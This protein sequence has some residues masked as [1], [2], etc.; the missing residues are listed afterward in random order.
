MNDGLRRG[1]F[2]ASL[3]SALAAC[4]P[5][6]GPA[7]GAVFPPS[8]P[9]AVVSLYHLVYTN[10]AGSGGIDA[11]NASLGSASLGTLAYRT[12][13]ANRGID[14]SS[15]AT[16][17]LR[18]SFA[19]TPATAFL[20]LPV[21]MTTGASYTL[22]MVGES[23]AASSALA[24]DLVIA[25]RDVTAPAVSRIRARFIHAWSNTGAVDIWVGPPGSETRQ[26]IGLNFKGVSQYLPIDAPLG[27]SVQR[28]LV[29][30]ANVA[31]STATLAAV[32]F[33]PAN[34][35]AGTVYG[36]LLARD[37]AG[38]RQLLNTQETGP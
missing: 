17:T 21:P 16:Q 24:P 14:L 22:V 13:V 6:P 36:V 38:T 25:Q 5:G 26:L 12:G 27:S 4:G 15:G 28:V 2:A 30:D 9:V 35:T 33:S 29:T 31:P 11:V 1:L 20:S 18:A 10:N 7:P 19:S 3:C 23:N 32:S 8:T 37:A 34:W